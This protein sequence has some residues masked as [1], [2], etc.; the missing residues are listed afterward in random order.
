MTCE[1]GND[2]YS[3]LNKIQSPKDLR[4]LNL[5]EL[6]TLCDELRSDIIDELPNAFKACGV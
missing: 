6:P 3:I 5:E 2:T 1:M 4:K